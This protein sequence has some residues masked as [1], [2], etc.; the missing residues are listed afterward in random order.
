M[1]CALLIIDMQ[2]FFFRENPA[3][4][5]CGFVD[6]CRKLLK[7][8]RDTCVP[9]VHVHTV[10][11]SD[12]SDWPEAWKSEGPDVWCNHLVKGV[13]SSQF[14]DG[15]EPLP[16]EAVV[17]KTRFSAFFN[18]T[19]QSVLIKHGVDTLVVAGYSCDVCIRF[20]CVDAYNFGYHIYL[21]SDCVESFKVPRKEA[22]VYLQWLTNLRLVTSDE[23]QGMLPSPG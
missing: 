2:R 8:G 22:C 5:R 15:L 3:A 18:T 1:K 7:W 6:N 12:K 19:L 20:T 4:L 9:I 13:E 23:L 10:Y 21:A 16:H 14:V 17:R 11:E